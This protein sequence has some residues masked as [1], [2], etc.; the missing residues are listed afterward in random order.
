M[1]YRCEIDFYAY[2]FWLIKSLFNGKYTNKMIY[3]FNY[4]SIY[5]IL[6]IFFIYIPAF[7]KQSWKRKSSSAEIPGKI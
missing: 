7:R 2:A 1:R 6:D 5:W 4:I 3:L